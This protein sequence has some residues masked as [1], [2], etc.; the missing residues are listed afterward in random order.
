[1]SLASLPASVVGFSIPYSSGHFDQPVAAIVNALRGSAEGFNPL[2]IKG[3]SINSSSVQAGGV[4][5]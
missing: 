1:M 5:K 2:F 3:T 4:A